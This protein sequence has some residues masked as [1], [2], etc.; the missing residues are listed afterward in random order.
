M[1]TE[2][3]FL[4]SCFMKLGKSESRNRGVCGAEL[5]LGPVRLRLLKLFEVIAELASASGAGLEVRLWN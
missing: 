5:R 1:N 2:K 3:V 4:K